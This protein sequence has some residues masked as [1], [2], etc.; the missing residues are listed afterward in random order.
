MGD[1]HEHSATCADNILVFSM[2]PMSIIR[3]IRETFVL[4]GAGKPEHCLGGDFHTVA[5]K[6][7]DNPQ[8]A[9][10]DDP[11]HHLSKN[12]SKRVSL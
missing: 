11:Q 9:G 4:K 12:G 10:N 8:E 3:E 1:H 5:D 6:D 2:N 7:V